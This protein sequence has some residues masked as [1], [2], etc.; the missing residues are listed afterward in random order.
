MDYVDGTDAARLVRD[1]YAH[2][3]PPKGAVEIVSAV[4]EALDY[5]HERYLLHRDV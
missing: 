4:A 3:L 1:R 5:A 2:G